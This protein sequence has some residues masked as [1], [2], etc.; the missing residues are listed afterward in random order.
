MTF[1]FE[2]VLF[3]CVCVCLLC[4]FFSCVCLY[5]WQIVQVFLLLSLKSLKYLNT[6]KATKSLLA[7]LYLHVFF[8]SFLGNPESN[9]HLQWPLLNLLNLKRKLKHIP[10][11][12]YPLQLTL[13]FLNKKRTE[14]RAKTLITPY[15]LSVI[16]SRS[17]L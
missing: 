14:K 12:H 11:R 17:A 16:T 13:F 10:R 9:S 1:S 2:S 7:L 3:L 15:Q 4:F 8:Q 5:F 6:R